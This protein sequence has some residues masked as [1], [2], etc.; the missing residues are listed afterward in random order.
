MIIHAKHQCFIVNT[1]EDMSQVKVLV[2][3]RRTDRQTNRRTDEWV[4]TPHFAKVRG[5]IA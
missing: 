3:D 5:Q 1:L 2:T 4:L